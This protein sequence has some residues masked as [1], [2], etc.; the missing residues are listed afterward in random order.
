M[1]RKLPPAVLALATLFL[2]VVPAHSQPEFPY[3]TAE[4]GEIRNQCFV[5]CFGA[6]CSASGTVTSIETSPPFQVRGIRTG[7]Y[8]DFATACAGAPSTSPAD[9]PL[10][11]GAG[12]FLVFDVDLVPT[13]TGPLEVPLVING[14]ESGRLTG[15][16][17]PAGPCPVSSP[18]T[19]CL[20]HDRFTV[21]TLWRTQYG[22]RGAAREVTGVPTDNSGLFYFFTPDNWE[23][24]I[25]VLAGCPINDHFWVFAAATTNVEY[26]LTVL[27]TEAQKVKVY[28]SPLGPAAQ[29][30]Q[31]T[32]AFATCP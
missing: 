19:L 26:T 9:L 3:G 13:A 4:L 27:D 32:A 6:D 18:E 25:K 5:T 22:T 30:I 21:R 23:M 2:G 16:V 29:P 31:D 17:V 10:D 20:D 12:H 24:L 8:A 1:T 28:S 14:E 15:T 7:D 11:L